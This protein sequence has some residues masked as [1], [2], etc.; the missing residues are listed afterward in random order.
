MMMMM[1]KKTEKNTPYGRCDYGIIFVFVRDNYNIL[2]NAVRHRVIRKYEN[3]DD[4][5]A[6]AAATAAA[7]GFLI[8]FK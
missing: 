2:T 6:A 5:T 1:K 3:G 4:K 7:V 8:T